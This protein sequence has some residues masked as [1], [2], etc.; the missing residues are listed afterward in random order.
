MIDTEPD[1][2]AQVV[3][4]LDPEYGGEDEQV[5]PFRREDSADRDHTPVSAITG[6]DIAS[7]RWVDQIGIWDHPLSWDGLPSIPGFRRAEMAP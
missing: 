7:A 1:D 2:G 4:Y 5:I 3:V 6:Y